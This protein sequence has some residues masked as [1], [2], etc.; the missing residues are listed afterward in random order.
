MKTDILLGGALKE[1]FSMI[2]FPLWLRLIIYLQ[3]TTNF[4]KVKE[5]KK[6]FWNSK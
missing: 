5:I 6:M 4:A 2:F 3:H 1:R